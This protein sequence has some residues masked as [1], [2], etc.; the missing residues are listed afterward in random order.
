[1]ETYADLRKVAEAM[2]PNHPQ[3]VDYDILPFDH[4]LHISPRH[5]DSAEVLLT[6]CVEHKE[7][8]F[9]P[10]DDCEEGCLKE[11]IDKLTALGVQRAGGIR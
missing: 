8:H 1:M 2:L 11:I 5:P 7:H 10:V 3:S 6:L 4:A 9:S